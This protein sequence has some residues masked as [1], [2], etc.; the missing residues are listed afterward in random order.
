MTKPVRKVQRAAN[1]LETALGWLEADDTRSDI[2]RA[3][4]VGACLVLIRMA[5]EELQGV[6]NVEDGPAY[7]KGLLGAAKAAHQPALFEVPR[8]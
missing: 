5:L 2:G 4:A 3:R 8:G 7:E 1:D 6:T